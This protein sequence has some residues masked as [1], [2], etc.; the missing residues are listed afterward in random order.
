MSPL[1]K[2][3]QKLLT[4]KS[5]SAIAVRLL[6]VNKLQIEINKLNAEISDLASWQNGC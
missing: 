4:E 1:R 3:A 6:K 5:A 2:E